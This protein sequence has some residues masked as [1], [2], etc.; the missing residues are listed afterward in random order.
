MPG[1][2]LYKLYDEYGSRLLERNVRSFL[3]AKGKVNRGIR[4]TLAK[5]P[6]LFMAFN[7]GISLTAET[8]ETLAAAWGVS[9]FVAGHKSVEDGVEAPF[10]R[11]LLLNTDREAPFTAAAGERI[12]QLL[13][14]PV[15]LP[16][17]VEVDGGSLHT[18]IVP[19]YLK[20]SR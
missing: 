16:A 14:V 11:L 10:P 8:V 13:L 15:A 3:Q 19:G 1:R 6:G 9:L 12:A 5:S 20:A 4:D 18:V 2:V 7:N 17:P